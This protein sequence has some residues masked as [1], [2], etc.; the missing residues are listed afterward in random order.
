MTSREFQAAVSTIG[1]GTAQPPTTVPNAHIVAVLGSCPHALALA[2]AFLAAGSRVRLFS[3]S[4]ADLDA[5][6]AAGGITVRGDGPVGTFSVDPSSDV[7]IETVS[8]IDAAVTGADLV[9]VV[10]TVA[11]QRAMGI[12][13]AGA[14]GSGQVAL[15]LPGRTFGALELAWWLASDGPIVG[16]VQDLPWEVVATGPAAIHLGR[17]APV[18]VGTLPALAASGVAEALSRALPGVSASPTVLHSSLADATGLVDVPALVVGGPG[19]LDD[20]SELLPGAEPMDEAPAHGLPLRNLVQR[21]ADERRAVAERWGVR[22]LPPPSD[23]VDRADN[24]PPLPSGSEARDAVLER[25]AGSLVP[26]ASAARLADVPTPV[27][28]AVI[29]AVSAMFAVDLTSV[30][31]RLENL[32]LADAGLDAIRRTVGPGRSS[33]AGAH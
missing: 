2:A 17:A 13:L 20:P 24:A 1:A 30:G 22:D 7:H 10:G 33:N 14:L 26:L 23:W 9:I 4:S 21:L 28:D 29:T 3:T 31:R 6:S 32:G 11:F 25:T 16:E 18:R 27:T 12:L 19:T 8:G 15:A 5:L